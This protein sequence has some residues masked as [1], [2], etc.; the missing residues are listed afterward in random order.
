METYAAGA[1]PELSVVICSHNGER[2]LP[3]AL[4]G[5]RGQSLDAKR[6]EVIVVD[7]GS[8]DATASIATAHGARVVRLDPNRGIA[9]ARNAGVS[10]ARGAIV[11]FTDDDCEPEQDWL[12]ALVVSFADPGT[13]GVG[14]QVRPASNDGFVLR[15]LAVRRPLAPL[16][17]DLLSS[18]NLGY[19]LW[20]YLR[21]AVGSGAPLAAG[22]SL[23]SVVGA[24]MAF[25][26]ELIFELGGF[27]EA[28]VFGGEEEDL[29]RRAHARAAGARLLYEPAA[30]VRHRFEPTLRDTLRRSRAY[31]KGNARSARK[32]ADV[33]MIL[34]PSP[35]LALAMILAAL[36]SRRRAP[37]LLGAIIPLLG[38]ARWPALAW[39]TRSPEALVYPYLQLAEEAWTMLGELEGHKAGYTAVPNTQLRSERTYH[40]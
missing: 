24:N 30:V 34:Y 12:A 6:F 21:T 39:R 33:R 25:R 36:L 3:S 15:Y 26:R 27:D 31:G 32:D 23:Y 35:V 8:T 13:E 11:A 17:G 29:C 19:R 37:A 20:L 40:G 28:F 2:M 38:Y 5:L 4:E 7:D 9:A 22:A 1:A 10:A 14:G 18:A 16:G